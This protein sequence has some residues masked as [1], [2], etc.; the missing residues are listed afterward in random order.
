MAKSTTLQKIIAEAKRIQK[1][2]THMSW[3]EAIKDAS[4][5]IKEGAKTVV[6]K[7]A[8]KKAVGSTKNLGY[9]IFEGIDPRTGNPLYQ[10]TNSNNY[11]E[12]EWHKNKKDA[13]KE[14]NYEI[15]RAAS[16][17]AVI[18]SLPVNFVGSFV[19][20]K[21]KIVNQYRID[22]GVTAQ[23][24]QY[25]PPGELM[26]QLN[27]NKADVEPAVDTIYKLVFKHLEKL[28]G[29]KKPSYG[30]RVIYQGEGSAIRIDEEKFTKEL[31]GKIKKF[32]ELLSNDV[33]AFNSGKDKNI[34]VSKP[35]IKELAAGIAPTIKRKKEFKPKVTTTKAGVVDQIKSVLKANHKILTHGYSIKAGKV[36]EVK[37]GH[38]T[39]EEFIEDYREQ[40]RQMLAK[41]LAYYE[42][43]RFLTNSKL[44][45]NKLARKIY[46]LKKFFNKIRK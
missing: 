12:G 1:V 3:K 41:Q 26:A 11:Y 31:K 20:Y 35:T 44:E 43:E 36:R 30:S 2:H 18:E 6:K 25:D 23:I 28:S 15:K 5:H 22:G 38:L 33:K 39:E 16:K 29:E 9:K 40:A 45:K 32:I 14:M 27:G 8:S 46:N 7:S 34:T 17:K 24:V 10:V 13:I 37:I 19:G 4:K 42:S 21:F